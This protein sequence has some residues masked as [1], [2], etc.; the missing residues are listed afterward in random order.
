MKT[1]SPHSHHDS[2]RHSQNTEGRWYS[3]RIFFFTKKG[4]QDTNFYQCGADGRGH[5]PP[6]PRLGSPPL[7]QHETRS[8]ITD[9][10]RRNATGRQQQATRAITQR[11][12]PEKPQLFQQTAGG[13]ERAI[14]SVGVRRWDGKGSDR[15]RAWLPAAATSSRGVALAT[16][17]L[18]IFFPFHAC[19]ARQ[20]DFI[21][22]NTCDA[23]SKF[24][25][26]PRSWW[27]PVV[28][29]EL[30]FFGCAGRICALASPQRVR[31]R[32][33]TFFWLRHY[34]ARACLRIRFLER[35]SQSNSWGFVLFF[36]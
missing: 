8:Q 13:T 2:Q 17:I 22:W 27:Q 14:P 34:A 10:T 26:A 33:F 36:D 12:L 4:A 31:D 11:T 35:N 23:R 28:I 30:G 20:W 3:A 32:F 25:L 21:L 9:T 29:I 15:R 7:R 6:V 19:S 1:T 16:C 5:G 18:G 24:K